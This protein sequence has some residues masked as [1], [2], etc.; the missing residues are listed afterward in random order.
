MYRSQS[1]A[2]PK[3]VAV[4]FG[5]FALIAISSSSGNREHHA[6]NPDVSSHQRGPHEHGP[7]SATVKAF[8]VKEVATAEPTKNE[9]SSASSEKVVYNIYIAGEKVSA[10]EAKAAA[11]EAVRENQEKATPKASAADA[12]DA[13]DCQ[14][15]SSCCHQQKHEQKHEQEQKHGKD[16]EAK[17]T[18]GPVTAA[19]AEKVSV[20]AAANHSHKPSAKSSSVPAAVLVIPMV[21]LAAA[22]VAVKYRKPGYL[23]DVFEERLEAAG[24][25]AA[26]RAPRTYN[27][28][29]SSPSRSMYGSV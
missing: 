24:L 15:N 20:R 1:V 2:L 12:P 8:A 4:V 16:A 27:S 28:W 26:G 29:T 3:V 9:A 17:S 5:L 6:H 13:C 21:A 23:P 14:K 11:V 22:L 18:A 25:P 19:T 10:S 7:E